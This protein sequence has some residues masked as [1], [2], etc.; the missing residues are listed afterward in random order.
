MTSGSPTI[1][2]KWVRSLSNIIV[3]VQKLQVP[4]SPREIL[5]TTMGTATYDTSSTS[6]D[7]TSWGI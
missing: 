4:A 7:M 3:V 2:T 6:E 1:F 5:Q